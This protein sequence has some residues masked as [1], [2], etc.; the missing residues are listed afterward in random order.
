MHN[1]KEISALV[2]AAGGGCKLRTSGT[3]VADPPTAT[4]PRPVPGNGEQW[5]HPAAGHAVLRC[6]TLGDR[7]IWGSEL[8]A[9]RVI[10]QRLRFSV[11][12]PW[13][14]RCLFLLL[15][16]SAILYRGWVGCRQLGLPCRNSKDLPRRP[17]MVSVGN[18]AAGGTGKTPVVD[19]LLRWRQ[20]MRCGRR[21]SAVAMAA[22]QERG[23]PGQ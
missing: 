11:L 14:S 9:L 22:T 1:F 21:W 12:V 15:R 10:H 20:R 13:P 17:A 6:G 7:G 2:L 18:L 5:P 23:A 4:G 19:R 8:S 16:R 3:E